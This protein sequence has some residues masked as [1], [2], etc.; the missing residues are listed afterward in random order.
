MGVD[1]IPDGITVRQNYPNPFN[2]ETT[3]PLDL[4]GSEKQDVTLKIYN[5]NGAQVYK[6]TV[7]LYPGSYTSNSPFSWN[8][9]GASSGIYMY[10]FELASGSDIVFNKIMLIK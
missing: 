9:Q 6:Q 10:S 2:P 4:G 7:N 3:F 8:A 5:L 1:Y